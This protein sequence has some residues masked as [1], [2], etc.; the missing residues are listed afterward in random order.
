MAVSVDLRQ[1]V[2]DS[3]LRGE[4]SYVAVATRF[5]VGE[6]SVARWVKQYR[7]TGSLAPKSGPRGYPAV[8][9]G[10]NLE[11]L[12]ALVAE[13]RGRDQ[14]E[15]VA[16]MWQRHEIKTSTSAISRALIKHRI[17][18]KKNLSGGRRRHAREGG[19]A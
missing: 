8:L 3:Y 17:S 19:G 16:L 11:K 4:G 10:E 5:C 18:R 1:R 14:A 9:S 2:V 12:K 6:A 7:E 15:L 13:E